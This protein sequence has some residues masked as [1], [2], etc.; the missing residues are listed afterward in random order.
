[1]RKRPYENIIAWQES[2]KLCLMMYKITKKLPQE[3]RFALADQIRR[4]ASS[5]P[6]NIAEGNMKRS[7]KEKVRYY[8]IAQGSL[9]EV[10]CETKLALDLQYISQEQFEEVNNQLN[11]SSYLLTRLRSSLTKPPSDS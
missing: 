1:M 3:E 8:E 11:K 2:Y 6:I 9:E 4:A 10:H 5:V 7:L